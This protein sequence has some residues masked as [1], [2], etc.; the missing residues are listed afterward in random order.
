MIWRETKITF[1]RNRFWFELSLVDCITIFRSR[2]ST[3]G[4]KGFFSYLIP[5]HRHFEY[6]PLE[7][8][9]KGMSTVAIPRNRPPPH[10]PPPENN[11]KFVNNNW[12]LPL[13]C[14]GVSFEPSLIL[15]QMRASLFFRVF[16]LFQGFT[17]DNF[18]S[19]W[20]MPQGSVISRVR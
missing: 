18:H 14:V 17:V 19:E 3:L 9:A 16:S 12:Q 7:P 4:G 10:A 2:D 11:C 8:R 20:S 13:S 1:R 5:Y 6:G 15:C